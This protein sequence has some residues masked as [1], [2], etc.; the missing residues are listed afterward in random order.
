MDTFRIFLFL[1]FKINQN[2]YE[3]ANF[4]NYSQQSRDS[5]QAF[6]ESYDVYTGL[7]KN[8]F[9]LGCP[10][11]VQIPYIKFTQKKVLW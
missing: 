2:N 3:V 8:V 5:G 10:Y 6:L 1:S 9:S 7:K 11:W 4:Y